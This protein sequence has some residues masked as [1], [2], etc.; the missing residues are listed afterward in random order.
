MEEDSFDKL[1]PEKCPRCKHDLSWDIS[2]PY[3]SYQ[4]CEFCGWKNIFGV[5]A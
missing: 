2:S 1:I 3:E 5:V 4:Y